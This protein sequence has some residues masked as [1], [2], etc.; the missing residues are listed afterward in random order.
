MKIVTFVFALVLPA[1]VTLADTYKID[2]AH[3][4]IRFS[5][6]HLFGTAR[7]E[8]HRFSGTIEVDASQPEQSSVKAVIQLSSIDTKI[9][10]R[11][12]HLL[13]TDFFDA[14][15]FP[16]IT[17]RSRS[18]K[19][20]SSDSGNIPGELTMHGVTHPLT[21]HVKLLMKNST[22]TR[23]SVTT[24]PIHRKDFGLMFSGTA[25]TISGIGQAVTPSIEIES[26]RA[27]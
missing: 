25:E 13:G 11:D 12:D 20:T 8:F 10:K 23:W 9:R 5:V 18:V 26:V 16:E 27:D 19:Q 2:S 24:D 1:L 22:R 15:R 6:H 3:S 14:A 21:L 17:F 7:G 4:F